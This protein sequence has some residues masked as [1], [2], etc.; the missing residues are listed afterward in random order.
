MTGVSSA[1]ARAPS[2]DL[3]CLGSA[4]FDFSP[5]LSF[6]TSRATG[7]G[8]ISSC[9]S[10]NGR[11]PRIKSGVIFATEGVVAT[12]CSPFPLTMVG[13]GSTATWND[14][15]QSTFD[16]RISTDPASGDLGVQ[17]FITSGP[18][19]GDRASFVPVILAQRGLCLLGGV[20]SLTLGFGEL[21]LINPDSQRG[22]WRK[23]DLRRAHARYRS[24]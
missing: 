21:A 9:A 4:H 8:L 16:V 13:Y 23:F 2:V 20:R 6:S 5:P 3:L 22:T 10:P 18:F 14:G 1:E 24:Q 12:G 11:Y 19:A 17:T 15:T 7:G